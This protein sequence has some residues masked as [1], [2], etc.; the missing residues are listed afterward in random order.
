VTSL[1]HSAFSIPGAPLI[2]KGHGISSGLW[3]WGKS[4]TYLKALGWTMTLCL[5]LWQARIAMDV[6]GLS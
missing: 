1:C 3:T 5:S 2:R 6:V 4:D